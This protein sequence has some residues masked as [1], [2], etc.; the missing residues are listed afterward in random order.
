MSIRPL[1]RQHVAQVLAA[2]HD[3]DQP[4]TADEFI[5]QHPVEVAEAASQLV[6]D[7]VTAAINHIVGE[8][9]EDTGQLALLA[10][11]PSAIAVAPGV[12]RPIDRCTWA[13]IE[14]GRR[15][16]VQNIAH[17]EKWLMRYDADALRVRPF[18][19]PHPERTVGDV[20]HLIEVDQAA[21][22]AS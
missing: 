16:R 9:P 8:R 19:E 15:V 3:I 18:L 2:G 1:I 7:A 17:A 21:E 13:D 11:L 5:A 12:V 6:R 10:G 4:R 14:I 22:A 20:R